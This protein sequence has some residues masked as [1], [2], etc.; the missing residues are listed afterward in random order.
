MLICKKNLYEKNQYTYPIAVNFSRVTIY[1]NSFYQR[2]LDTVKEYEIPFK[3]IEIEVTES[4]FN[5]ISQPVILILEELKKLGFLI[6]MDDFGSGYSSLSL[7][8]SLSINGL[9]LDKSLLKET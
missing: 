6:S 1:Q 2:F 4:A 9:K 5:E 7:L 3:Y 8:C